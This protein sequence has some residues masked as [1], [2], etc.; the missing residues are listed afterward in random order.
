MGTASDRA[1]GDEPE[2]S[3]EPES[4]SGSALQ[5][6]DI[7]WF[8]LY[9]LSEGARH[10]YQL[11][12]DIERKTGGAYRPSPG[13]LYPNLAA[14]EEAGYVKAEEDEGRRV[15]YL[16]KA[17]EG[18]LRHKSRRVREAVKRVERRQLTPSEKRRSRALV[19]ELEEDLADFSRSVARRAR[20]LGLDLEALRHIRRALER[21]R[22]EV[23]EAIDQLEE[24][25]AT[26]SRSS[27]DKTS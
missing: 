25:S 15:Y 10:G 26:F 11:L 21:A 24:G 8:L 19:G 18:V 17:G 9:L 5:K 2:R 7:K 13:M 27:E 4:D 3:D 14:L 16:T 12:K 20:H 1:I 22:M 23:M 6:G